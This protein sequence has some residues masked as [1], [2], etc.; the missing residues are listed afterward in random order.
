M[1]YCVWSTYA[2]QTGTPINYSHIPNCNETTFSAGGRLS[3]TF[4]N[5]HHRNR[6]SGSVIKHHTRETLESD[7]FSF[8]SGG[9]SSLKLFARVLVSVFPSKSPEGVVDSA[10]SC[11]GGGVLNQNTG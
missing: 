3:S 1:L 4:Y 6:Y 2:L 8:F 5:A 10:T 7:L 9:R 11:I